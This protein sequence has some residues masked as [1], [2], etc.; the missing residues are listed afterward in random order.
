MDK[1]EINSCATFL[2][3]I[4]LGVPFHSFTPFS[5]TQF[6]CQL[7]LTALHTLVGHACSDLQ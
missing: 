2:I 6:N 1:S 3:V 4:A 5:L 7:N